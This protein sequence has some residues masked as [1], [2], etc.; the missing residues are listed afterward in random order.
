MN[1]LVSKRLLSSTQIQVDTASSGIECLKLTQNSLY[2]GILMDHMMPEMDGITCLH[3]LRSQSG[4][5]CRETPVIALT[6][7]AGGDMQQLYKR[8]GFFGYLA[9]PVSGS[10][11]EAAVLKLLPIEK[12]QF[13]DDSMRQDADEGILLKNKKRRI[14]LLITTDSVCDL[15]KELINYYHIP[16]LPYY[17]RTDKGHFLDGEEVE[18]NDLLLYLSAGGNASSEPPTMADYEEFFAQ[19]LTEAQNIIHISMARNESKGYDN[20]A[21]AAQCFENVTIFDSGQVSSGMGLFVLHAAKMASME[22]SKEEILS[23]LPQ[24]F[25]RISSSFIVDNTKMLYNAG[26]IPQIV[27]RFCDIMMLHPILV[28]K[29]SKL[30]VNSINIGEK[31]HVIRTYIR[32]TLK[33]SNT[34]DKRILIITYIGMDKESLNTI[35]KLVLKQCIFERIYTQKASPT[36]SCNCGAGMFGLLFMRKK[37]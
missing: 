16:I 11:L 35:K 29:K 31:E 19:R 21:A 1:L 27:Q 36:I 3:A 14:P 34:I 5:S 15:P 24:L 4:G 33:D 25:S 9:K 6:A 12:V 2:D 18:S 8:E 22:F 37:P 7:N 28:L 30:T 23:E 26:K 32:H 20:A 10:L 17:V 13:L